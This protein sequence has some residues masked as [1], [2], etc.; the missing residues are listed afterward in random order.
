MVPT[1]D[2]S[3]A[4]VHV[5][6]TLGH[7]VQVQGRRRQESPTDVT[8]TDREDLGTMTGSRGRG[9]G[10]VLSR[11]PGWFVADLPVPR[12][13]PPLPGPVAWPGWEG[14]PWKFP[15][16]TPF[17]QG[18]VDEAR[19]GRVGSGRLGCQTMVT[20]TESRLCPPTPTTLSGPAPC[21]ALDTR[22]TGPVPDRTRVPADPGCPGFGRGP[23]VKLP[24]TDVGR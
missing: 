18:R 23:W 24:P 2:R 17:C 11:V 14:S 4:P 3:P 13:V 10:L 15:T 22:L 21:R 5:H 12:T 8:P 1:P 19:C 16:V 9:Q 20:F 6:R 7:Q